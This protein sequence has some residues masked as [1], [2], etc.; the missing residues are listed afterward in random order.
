MKT[1]DITID[2]ETCSL[3]SHAAIMQIAAVIWD[4]FAPDAEYIF[5]SIDTKM[6]GT[7]MM[8]FDHP[9]TIPEHTWHFCENIDLNHQFINGGM[10]FSQGTSDWWRK[11][12]PEAKQAVIGNG[13]KMPL[14]QAIIKLD[15]WIGKA[16]RLTGAKSVNIWCQGTDFDIP[17]LRNAAEVSNLRCKPVSIPHMFYRDCRTFVYEMTLLYVQQLMNGEE[18][19]INDLLNNPLLAYNILPEMPESFGGRENAHGALY[20]CVRSSW[21]TWQAMHSLET[22]NNER[23]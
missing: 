19:P 18:G 15:S 22:I 6:S 17:I 20:D 12:S 16:M 5:P 9:A 11:Q 13:G 1:L 7:Q 14:D 3:S 21:F 2:L 10:D 23:K 4:R 8:D